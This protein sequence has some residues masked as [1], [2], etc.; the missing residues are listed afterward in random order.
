MRALYLPWE[1]ALRERGRLFDDLQAWTK[2][3][4]IMLLDLYSTRLRTGTH[5][6]TYHNS[7]AALPPT[8]Q[9]NSPVRIVSAEEFAGIADFM[10]TARSRGFKI[11]S[12]VAPLFIPAAG[13]SMACVDFT[14]R[15]LLGPKDSVFYGCPNNPAV[16]DYGQTF[17]RGLIGSWPAMDY[18]SL[19]HL[20]Y[21]IN[22]FT[23]YPNV[24]LRDL[25]VCFCEWCQMRAREEE[26]DLVGAKE[27]VAS[28]FRSISSPRPG[29][30]P[31]VG[32]FSS[33]DVLTFLVKRPQLTTWLDF[34]RRSMT[35][36]AR[37]LLDA[38]R[39][40][41]SSRTSKLQVGFYFQLPSLSNLVGTD[42]EAL[43]PLFDYA[44]V[45]FPDYIPGSVL[46]I[47]TDKV[48]EK[49]RRGDKMVLRSAMRELLDLGPGPKKYRPL[50]GMKDVL[51][52]SNATDPSMVER[53]LKRISGLKPRSK[54][55]PHV[56]EHNGDVASLR[57]KMDV[58]RMHGFRD[59]TV[60]AFE[61]GLTRENLRAASGVI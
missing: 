7:Q 58:L 26:F 50:G 27:E 1:L 34:R 5:G 14:G 15:K 23:S 20:E 57:A 55:I 30:R 2:I 39:S 49:A 12:L 28:L 4:T 41:S 11:A 59:Y 25:F 60:W 42:H 16:V 3:D 38:C 37:S 31:A 46:P 44:C 13:E 32:S 40:A 43:F 56:W 6:V 18:L 51:L 19:D 8:T 29:A 24:D 10:R 53:Q 45:K 35:R 36:Y 52:Y 21:P 9:F 22:L 48:S 33:A 54:V 17:V 61:D 47:I